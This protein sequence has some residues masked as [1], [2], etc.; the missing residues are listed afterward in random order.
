MQPH[1]GIHHIETRRTRDNLQDC[2]PEPAAAGEG[3]CV[4]VKAKVLGLI[5]LLLATTA[6]A[7]DTCSSAKKDLDTFLSTLPTSC[8]TDADCT[9]RYM[10]AD[11]CDSPFVVNRSA[12]VTDMQTFLRLPAP[13][14]PQ[15]FHPIR[16]AHPSRSA[17]SAGR[18]N[19]WTL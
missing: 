5:L 9:G 6:F 2:H 15:N 11:S 16:S 13:P 19:V 18:T 17:P 7:G 4:F 8:T 12:K 10:R 14:A 3:P 1:P